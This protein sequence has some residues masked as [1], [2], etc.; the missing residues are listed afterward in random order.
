MSKKELESEYTN[1]I[2]LERNIDKALTSASNDVRLW[3]E[4]L[5][6]ARQNQ[7]DDLVSSAISVL[8]N[9][10]VQEMDLLK[11]K[12]QITAQKDLIRKTIRTAQRQTKVSIPGRRVVDDD[13]DFDIS[14]V[15]EDDL[16]GPS[17]E[18]RAL[19]KQFEDLE[20]NSAMAQL[21]ERLGKR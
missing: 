4:R 11:Q 5:D 18:E 14:R 3:E 20:R 6:L 7:R 15:T 1:L 12:D 10:K 16:F 19:E 13:D 21:K 17:E 2:L 9:A 8:D